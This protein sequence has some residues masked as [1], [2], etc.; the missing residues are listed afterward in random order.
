MNIPRLKS[1]VAI[2][3]FTLS[4]YTYASSAHHAAYAAVKTTI[5]AAKK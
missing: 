4:V 1:F 5:E 2:V 3:V